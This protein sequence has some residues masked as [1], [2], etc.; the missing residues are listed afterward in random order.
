M[1]YI[2][3]SIKKVILFT[4]GILL[5]SSPILGTRVSASSTDNGESCLNTVITNVSA[6]AS[7]QNFPASAVLDM[8][9]QSIWSTYGKGAWIEMD[10]GE[11]KNVCSVD[12]R[13]YKGD[14]RRNNFVISISTDGSSYQNVLDS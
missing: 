4:I 3:F 8:N 12:I 11:V 2:T 10:L 9:P 1:K 5:I 13:W 14:Q 6:I 7:D